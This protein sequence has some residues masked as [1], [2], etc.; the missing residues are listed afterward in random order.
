MST[1][2]A[3][4]LRRLQT[5]QSSQ[6]I[7][8]KKRDSI[9]FTSKEAATKSRETVY[10]IGLSG[11]HELIEMNSDFEEFQST[12]FELTAK[13][14]QRAVETKEVN[15][16]L[17]KNIK[18][19]M[20]HLSPYFMIPA[21]HKCLE[22][23]IRRFNINL[24]NKE[25][26]LMLILPYH[27]TNMFVRCVQVM[28]FDDPTNKWDFLSEVKKSSAPLSKYALW[29]HGATQPSFLGFVG[30][31]THEAIK[32]VNHKAGSLQTMIAFYCTT[33]IGAMEQAA[34]INDN[35][36]LSIVKYLVKS[37]KS[38]VI[39][40]AAAGYMITA[41]LLVKAKLGV[42]LLSELMDKITSTVNPSL[43]QNIILLLSLMFQSQNDDLKVTDKALRNIMSF[44][45]LLVA[46]EQMKTEGKPMIAFYR[47]LICKLLEKIGDKNE[48][49]I[50]Y[51]E[52]CES[53]MSEVVLENDEAQ[54]IIR[55]VTNNFVAFLVFLIF[56]HNSR[57]ILDSYVLAPDE[58][59]EQKE[60][61]KDLTEDE[62][63]D[64]GIISLDSDDDDDNIPLKSQDVTLWYST[65][66]KTLERQYPVAFDEVVKVVM[67][68]TPGRKRNGLKNVLGEIPSIIFTQNSY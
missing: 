29:N 58:S 38:D 46:F 21:T 52:Y 55:L 8:T 39:D 27:Q 32:E 41:Q 15:A 48:D 6:F 2:L 60:E 4:Q 18:R 17:N 47:A 42:P 68:T 44:K 16:L 1:S 45:W 53:L 65:F 7:D 51:K 24:Y 14:V 40:F 62:D 26:L 49:F 67:S 12:L 33:I 20:F 64:E 10:E 36:L 13:D 43:T 34:S 11:L 5:P 3:E 23:L 54:I 35:H 59:E 63:E 61:K 37:Y 56:G 30:K 66:L 25:E 28:K 57:A 50:V 19:F 22:W 31:F 9:L